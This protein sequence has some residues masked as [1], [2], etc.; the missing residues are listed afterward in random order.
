MDAQEADKAAFGDRQ[1]LPPS[2]QFEQADALPLTP[3]VRKA[4][5]RDVAGKA[6]FF[7]GR[8][9]V[10]GEVQR[11]MIYG[12]VVQANSD[13]WLPGTGEYLPA[14]LYLPWTA[15]IFTMWNG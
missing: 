14:V 10:A 4:A 8:G 9:E 2:L 5:F 13:L 3:A 11:P 12:A 15:P 6:P 1:K 7:G